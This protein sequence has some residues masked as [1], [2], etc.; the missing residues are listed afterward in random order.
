[1]LSQQQPGQKPSRQVYDDYFNYLGLRGESIYFHHY[2]PEEQTPIK[3]RLKVYEDD[4]NSFEDALFMLVNREDDPFANPA[5]LRT[6]EDEDEERQKHRAS[7]LEVPIARLKR[8][9]MEKIAE[10]RNNIDI[11]EVLMASSTA[12]PMLTEDPATEEV[13]TEKAQTLLWVDKYMPNH[14]NELLS[15][16]RVNREL[17]S[18]LKAWDPIVFHRN[19]SVIGVGMV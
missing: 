9:V 17:L 4:G 12:E 8:E 13:A 6:M 5:N 14:Y 16:E 7:L 19:V 3:I 18:W 1:M 11:N 2:V 15:D 10:E